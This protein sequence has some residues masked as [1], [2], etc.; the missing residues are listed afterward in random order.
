MKI[1]I[2]DI[3][4]ILPETD[5]FAEKTCNICIE[6]DTIVSTDGIP[7]GFVPDKTID[8]KGKF[9]SAGLINCHAHS[10]MTV[11]RNFADDLSF[12][13]WLFEKI[14]PR[15]DNMS[16]KDAYWGALLACR[17]MLMS[18]TTTFLDM[19]MFPDVCAEA[20]DKSGIRAVLSRGIVGSSRT[21][22]G[23]IRR[24]NEALNEAEKWKN[25]SRLTFALGPHAIYTTE[26]P[27]LEWVAELAEETGFPVNVHLSETEYE[28]SECIKKYGVT[29]VAYLDDIGL[30]S[31]KTI[32]AHCVHLTDEDIDILARRKVNVA[33]NP[34]SNLKLGNG[35]APVKKMLEKGI[36]LCIGTDGAASN[37]SLN[38][39]G[40]I[41]YTAMIHKGTN[42]NPQCISAQ[43][44]HRFATANGAKALGLNTGRLEKGMK[45]DIVLYDLNRP[46]FCPKN[47]IVAALAYSANGSEVDTVIVDGNIV[48]EHS[49]A[50]FIDDEELY[51]NVNRIAAEMK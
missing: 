1:L 10:Y 26:R 21:D 13:E 8:G 42:M 48:V 34:K 7:D 50:L 9:A 19:H 40:D 46:Q 15:E 43:D 51:Y 27:F 31:E 2:K 28:V 37:N 11:F 12:N 30:L 33:L 23:G 16:S 25:N 22:P 18:G 20:V 6:N 14:M 24:I 32:A 4:A 5:G 39:F 36:N 29:P 35:F 44:V 45:A 41:N 49:K 47:D 3:P 38:L 17:E